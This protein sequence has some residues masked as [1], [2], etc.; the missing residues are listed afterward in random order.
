MIPKVFV[1]DN[2][3]YKAEERAILMQDIDAIHLLSWKAQLESVENNYFQCEKCEYKSDVKSL[4]D[5]H[6]EEKHSVETENNK[7]STE[8]NRKSFERR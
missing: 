2:C 7:E 8:K 1:C 3:G 5:K 4:L 6:R